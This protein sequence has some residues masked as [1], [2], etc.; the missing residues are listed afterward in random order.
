MFS[1]KVNEA[2]HLWAIDNDI[3]LPDAH[4]SDRAVQISTS[5]HVQALLDN[6]EEYIS[7]VK[8]VVAE[9]LE[10]KHERYIFR[11]INHLIFDEIPEFFGILPASLNTIWSLSSNEDTTVFQ[12]DKEKYSFV[13][14]TIDILLQMIRSRYLSAP[15]NVVYEKLSIQIPILDTASTATDIDTTISNHRKVLLRVCQWRKHPGDFVSAGDLLAVIE[16]DEVPAP[17]EVRALKS[18]KI[19]KTLAASGQLVRAYYYYYYY[20]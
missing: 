11:Q 18:G 13:D 19:V 9:V 10:K 7:N 2:G 6:Q 20:F 3:L 4:S 8:S 17:I 14:S 12:Y 16:M 5:N 1:D 15:F